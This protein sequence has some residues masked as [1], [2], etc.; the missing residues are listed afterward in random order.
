MPSRLNT[1][2]RKVSGTQKMEKLRRVTM[3]LLDSQRS[4]NSLRP[5]VL[6]MTTI[7]VDSQTVRPSSQEDISGGETRTTNGLALSSTMAGM[8]VDDFVRTITFIR[9]THAAIVDVRKRFP[10]RPARVLY[11][12]CGPYA[13]L[14]V[15]LMAIFSSTEAIFTCLDIHS[16]SIASAKSII[17]TLGFSE[18]AARFETLDAGSYRVC[19]D[20]TPDVILMEIMQACLETEPQVA[21]TRH[22]LPQAPEAILIPEEVQVDLEL[23]DPAS[24]FNFDDLERNE[25]VQRDRIPVASVFVVNRETVNLWKNNHSNR[26]PGSSI[27]IPDSMEQWFQLMLFTKIRIYKNHCL[28]DYDSGLTC[29]RILS[30]EGLLNAGD[31]IQ[32][33]YELG[34]QPRLKGEVCA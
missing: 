9:G 24:E 28:K 19:P 13:T 26:L 29:P 33:H 32:F 21:I 2:V 22:L 8:C 25:E 5:E 14:A 10:G 17:D 16:E 31:A 20:Q 30:I 11:V 4:A 34:R 18:S 3:T 15:P 27:R 1:Y 23:V 6:E 7:L 12:G